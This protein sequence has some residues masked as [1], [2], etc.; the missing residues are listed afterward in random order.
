MTAKSK[1]YKMTEGDDLTL[2]LTEFPP[3]AVAIGTDVDGNPH[4]ATGMIAT[5]P[6]AQELYPISAGDNTGNIQ[7]PYTYAFA[8]A[9]KGSFTVTKMRIMC[10][11]AGGTSWPLKLGIVTAERVNGTYVYTCVGVAH[12]ANPVQ[13]LN[14]VNLDAPVSVE[15]GNMYYMAVY[16][17]GVNTFMLITNRISATLTPMIILSDPN[18]KIN[19]G[20]T[21]QVN[22][23]T[24]SRIW[25]EISQ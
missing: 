12:L 11:T 4:D 21:L 5:Y 6:I 1:Y 3:S 25:M 22:N 24:G 2:K 16:N 9:P 15:G 10:I 14:T 8:F 19:V 17:P 7:A 18:D 13:G 23:T 20:D